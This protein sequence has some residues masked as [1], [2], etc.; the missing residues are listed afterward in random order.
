MM[1]SKNFMLIWESTAEE[2]HPRIDFA[3]IYDYIHFISMAAGG[4]RMTT[5]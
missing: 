5:S 2:E 1:A 3:H 4:D